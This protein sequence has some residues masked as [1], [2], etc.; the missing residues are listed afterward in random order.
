MSDPRPIGIFDSGVGGLTVLRELRRALPKENFIYLG[1]TARA[2]YGT[3]SR[4]TVSRYARE[5]AQLLVAQ[6][7]KLIVVACNTASAL[8]L[9]ALQEKIDCQVIGVIEPAV[10]AAL[11]AAHT[12]NLAIIGTEATIASGAYQNALLTHNAQLKIAAVACP[13]FVPLVEEGILQGEIVQLA[14]DRYLAGLKGASIDTIILGCTHYP[15]LLPALQQYFGD[16]VNLIGCAKAVAEDSQELLSSMTALSEAGAGQ[17]KY[18]VTDD[19]ARFNRVARV[20]LQDMTVN[21][22]QIELVYE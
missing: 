14:I 5:C 17:A 8:A 13:L 20:F 4:Q 21:A 1:D 22:A 2:P 19:V 16:S 6:E 12:G 9:T 3:K 7:V 10:R 15:L 18:F 11:S